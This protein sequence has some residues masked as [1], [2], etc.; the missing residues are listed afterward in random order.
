MRKYR[1]MASD[2]DPHELKHEPPLE[3][4]PTRKTGATLKDI[5]LAVDQIR[6]QFRDLARDVPKLELRLDTLH[7]LVTSHAEDWMALATRV[8]QHDERL[9]RLETCMPADCRLKG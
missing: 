7:R 5:A 6:A 1:N 3:E 9:R 8:D 4:E 2:T